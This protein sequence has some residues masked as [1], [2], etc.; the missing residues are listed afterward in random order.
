MSD[1]PARAGAPGP[2]SPADQPGEAGP[3]EPPGLAGRQTLPGTAGPG[4]P[5]GPGSPAGPSAEAVRWE[6]SGPASPA[7]QSGEADSGGPLGPASPA[8]PPEV[9]PAR[10][11][12]PPYPADLS[13]WFD[14]RRLPRLYRFS[15]PPDPP[16]DDYLPLDGPLSW[17][18]RLTGTRLL[19]LA[20]IIAVASALVGGLV[21]GY[22][23][24]GPAAG[25]QPS[26]SL[27]TV[28]PALTNRPPDSVAGIAARVLPSVVMIKVNGDEGTG[29]GF[30]IR[31]GYIVTNNHVVTLD[32]AVTHATLQVV[33]NGGQTESARLVGADPYSDIAILRL[34]QQ[35]VRL[36]ALSLGNSGSVDV[37]DP[38]VAVGSPL[39]LANTVT[40]GIVSALNRP[41]QP[42]TGGSGSIPQ[43]FYDAIQ[44]DA[45]INP[46]NSGGPLVN[47]QA[48]VI[49]VNAA[50]DTLN[51]NPL[52][53]V[54]G[55]SIG[56]GFAIP[57]NH[58][59]VVATELIR[60]G[61]AT[62]SVIGALVN[63]SYTGNGAQIAS[64]RAGAAP[65]V[66]PGGP[67][68]QAGLQ[69]GDVIIRFA[70]QPIASATALLDAIRS[71]QPG[72]RVPVTFI[73]GGGAHT[74]TLVLGSAESLFPDV[75]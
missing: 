52:N 56:L 60:T 73:G 61:R 48:Q 5:P 9:L 46:G 38:V 75:T 1:G 41:V 15:D 11:A 55:G 10:A 59:R 49:G 74:V 27:G 30:I 23:G 47:A 44:T 19:V 72:T 29:S 53:G 65:S 70:G 64:S 34:L 14:L 4:E 22:I 31:G 36:P 25:T 42:G 37:G 35:P 18:G 69:P 21:G 58:A 51:A 50:I 45:P 12:N 63:D 66:S 20:L 6:P 26:Y 2:A 71:Q 3:G 62:H 39:G 33:F 28:P 67:A 57:I 8:H 17:S 13:C 68:A 32:G 54:Q 43:A 7:D 24:A 40:S 16:A